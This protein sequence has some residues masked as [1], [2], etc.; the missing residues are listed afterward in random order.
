MPKKAQKK[1]GSSN[2]HII[3]FVT[4]EGDIWSAKVRKDGGKW[5]HG[6]SKY[7]AIGDLIKERP[8]YFSSIEEILKITI[9]RTDAITLGR[10]FLHSVNMKK[11][12]IK[13]EHVPIKKNRERQHKTL[14][15]GA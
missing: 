1:E 6:K 13:V 8:E 11:H 15:A 3:I 14:P 9:S 7:E 5:G 12:G 4:R 2:G 10:R